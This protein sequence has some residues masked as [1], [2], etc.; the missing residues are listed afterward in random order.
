MTQHGVFVSYR[1]FVSDVGGGV[2]VCTREYI[3]TIRLAGYELEYCLFNADR[4]VSSR[5]ARRLFSSP[6]VRGTP[7]GLVEQVVEASRGHSKSTIFLN[8]VVLAAIAPRLKRELPDS[9]I[10]VLSHGLESTDLLHVARLRERLPIAVRFNPSPEVVLGH[11]LVKEA[12]LRSA[13]DVVFVLS[14]FDADLEKWMGARHVCWLPRSVVAAPLEW[15][16]RGDR[17]GFVGTLD[18]APNLD[19]LVQALDALAATGAS[20]FVVRVVGGPP[21]LASWLRERYP[22]VEALGALSDG[23]LEAE[24]G[25]WNAFL[26]PLFCLSR[27]CST[28]LA[29]ALAWQIPIVTTQL[30]HRG[31]V[32]KNGCLSIGDDPE[33]FARVSL[34]LLDRAKAEQARADVIA[35]AQSSPSFREN[36]ESMV[37]FLNASLG[38]R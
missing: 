16:P 32:W 38:T 8:Q 9:R 2:Q 13:I 4:R 28:K 29:A 23:E 35:A 18:H 11:A 31:Y 26:H 36:S 27:G 34:S 14:P 22:F 1:P 33:S 24:A 17:L 37:E 12:R 19:G 5:V 20:R 7:S 3:E 21:E 30:G 25:S 6:Y 15:K 10:V